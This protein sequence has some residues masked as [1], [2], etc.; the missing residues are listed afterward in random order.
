MRYCRLDSDVITKEQVAVDIWRPTSHKDKH[1]EHGVRREPK[2]QLELFIKKIQYF[3][4]TVHCID[5]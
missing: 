4:G 2:K 5:T 1:Y 3:E